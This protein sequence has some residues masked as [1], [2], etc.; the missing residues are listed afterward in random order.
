MANLITAT[1]VNIGGT[2]LAVSLSQAFLTSGI[3]IQAATISS[4]PTAVSKITYFSGPFSTIQYWSSDSVA[5]LVALA[6]TGTTSM[7]QVT[8]YKVGDYDQKSPAQYAF[9]ASGIVLKTVVQTPIVTILTCGGINYGVSEVESAI[10]TAANVGGGGG[11][12]WALTGTTTLTGGVTIDGVTNPSTIDFSSTTH[13]GVSVDD[14]TN[15]SGL[16]LNNNGFLLAA[17]DDAATH[18]TVITSDGT[19]LTF[20][21]TGTGVVKYGADYS[22]NFTAR[23][24]IDKGYLKLSN[25]AAAG[26]TNTIDN[27]SFLQNWK[28]DSLAGTSG[29]KLSSISTAAASNAQILFESALSGTNGTAAQTTYAGKF[30]NAHTGTTSTNIGIYVSASGGTTN[31]YAAVFPQ[32]TVGVGT[33]TPSAILS[34]AGD[35]P[36][37]VEG[38]M[39][40]TSGNALKVYFNG[41]SGDS[42]MVMRTSGFSNGVVL[43]TNG[44]SYFNGGKTGFGQTTPTALV[45]CGASTT[46]RASFNLGDAGTA[47]TSPNNGDMWIESGSFKVRLGGSTKTVTAV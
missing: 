35:I 36:F 18:A 42:S 27:T 32:G 19:D 15:G 23:S 26:A 14:A 17:G 7:V 40:L 1:V 13:F 9:P 2:P 20:I 46:A 24:L 34:V 8:V 3:K 30:T 12:G 45:H 47:P 5:T 43:N 16:Q 22:A 38:P 28:W 44:D 11:G 6:N 10:V 21:I 41:I 29:L 33:A 25:I 37:Q 31:N 4:S 39:A